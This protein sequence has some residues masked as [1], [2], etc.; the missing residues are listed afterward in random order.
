MLAST[1]VTV[2]YNVTEAGFRMLD[3]IWTC[4]LMTV[5]ISNGV[6]AGLVG[7]KTAKSRARHSGRAEETPAAAR[8]I[9]ENEALPLPDAEWKPSPVHQLFR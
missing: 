1:I 3:P 9:P 8:S 5:V 6:A 7:R 4:L 2:S